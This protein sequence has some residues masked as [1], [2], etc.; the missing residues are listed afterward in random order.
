MAA[1]AEVP[2]LAGEWDHDS[3]SDDDIEHVAALCRSADGVQWEVGD[4]LLAR[5]PMGDSREP[6]GA[7]ARVAELAEHV[8]WSLIRLLD[9]RAVAHAWPPAARIP[10]VSYDAHGAYRRG[11]PQRAL[12]RRA[13]LLALP[14]G[15]R[16]KLSAASVREWARMEPRAHTTAQPRRLRTECPPSG[17]PPEVADLLTRC[18]NVLEDAGALLAADVLPAK[19][20]PSLDAL[21]AAL[22]GVGEALA[23]ARLI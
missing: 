10:D 18:E 23:Q 15:R 13:Q 21:I 16:G 7:H 19:C 11:G 5:V 12:E 4:F 6:T 1:L 14:R 17:L 3:W 20:R 9:V 8:D 2:P 22:N